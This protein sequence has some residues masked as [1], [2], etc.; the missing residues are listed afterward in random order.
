M[1]NVYGWGFGRMGRYPS[2]VLAFFTVMAVV[3]VFTVFYN[4]TGTIAKWSA[5]C[6]GYPFWMF[7][8]KVLHLNITQLES[9]WAVIG[10]FF[11][12]VIIHDGIL[13]VRK[14]FR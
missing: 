3:V 4:Y 11:G 8:T 2:A 1:F 5:E 7:F 10:F 12:C 9:F 13:L 14:A 6:L